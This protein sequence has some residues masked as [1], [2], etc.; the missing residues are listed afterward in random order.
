MLLE[1]K[2]TIG[3]LRSPYAR[4]LLAAA[5]IAAGSV[6]DER[7]AH[8]GEATLTRDTILANLRANEEL[9]ANR[10]VRWRESFHAAASSRRLSQ[11]GRALVPVTDE[12]LECW[13]V[14]QDGKFFLECR[15]DSISGPQEKPQLHPIHVRRGFDRT[16]TRLLELAGAYVGNVI[17]GAAYDGRIFDP[18][19]VVRRRVGWSHVAFPLS[20]YLA[21]SVAIRADPRAV[22]YPSNGEQ[23]VSRYDGDEEVRGL[24]CH[25]IVVDR[26]APMPGKDSKIAP[27][28]RIV[29]WLA[30][31]R[32]D[33]PI[34]TDAYNLFYSGDIPIEQWTMDDLRQVA[35]GIWFPFRCKVDVLDQRELRRRKR[36]V[37]ADTEEWVVSEASVNPKHDVSFFRDVSFPD[38]TPVYEITDHKITRSYIQGDKPLAAVISNNPKRAMR[39]WLVLV[40]VVAVLLMAAWIGRKYFPAIRDRQ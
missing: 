18:H 13:C 3:I 21:G 33:L 8:A 36:A 22:D 26:R 37:V 24:R 40:N 32:N 10:E 16:Q 2:S 1:C 9:Y 34:K 38:G 5:V 7:V 39:W 14:V 35:P 4:C 31:D 27:S 28:D 23:I 15:G 20:V 29:M 19:G 25:R 12:Q 17:Q 6:C 11:G 30:I